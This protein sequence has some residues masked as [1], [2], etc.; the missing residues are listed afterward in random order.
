MEAADAIAANIAFTT[1]GSLVD[2]VDS[3]SSRKDAFRQTVS[4]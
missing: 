3:E 2:C 4:C 1:S